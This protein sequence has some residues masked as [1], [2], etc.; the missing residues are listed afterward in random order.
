MARGSPVAGMSTPTV[1]S[2]PAGRCRCGVVRWLLAWFARHDSRRGPM[3]G[4]WGTLGLVGV[5]IVLNAVFAGSE[6]ALISLREGQLKALERRETTSARA[7]VRLAR[8]PNRFLATIQVG[9]TLAGF[10]ASATAA[11]ALAETRAR[12]YAFLGTGAK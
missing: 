2:G 9:I 5:L 10:L 4:Y 3:D 12:V 1:R 7:L 8:D 11:V 6:I